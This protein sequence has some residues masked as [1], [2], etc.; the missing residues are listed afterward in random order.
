MRNV[1]IL[2]TFYLITTSGCGKSEDKSGAASPPDTKKAASVPAQTSRAVQTSGAKN[3]KKPPVAA[4]AAK[5]P[6]PGPSPIEKRLERLTAFMDRLGQQASV[7][8]KKLL[9]RVKLV[10]RGEK[11]SFQDLR[12]LRNIM[13]RNLFDL[14]RSNGDLSDPYRDY[15]KNMGSLMDEYSRCLILYSLPSD[16]PGRP[17]DNRWIRRLIMA[18]NDAARSN[19]ALKGLPAFKK[20]LDVPT[21]PMD[22]GTYA[23]KLRRAWEDMYKKALTWADTHPLAAP[24][25]TTPPKWMKHPRREKVMLLFMNLDTTRT[26]KWLHMLKCRPHKGKAP[27]GSASCSAIYDIMK[28]AQ[29][30]MERFDSSWLDAVQELIDIE[31]Q[32]PSAMNEKLSPLVDE[33]REMNGR[34]QKLR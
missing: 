34:I 9:D 12:E 6:T 16:A 13:E 31:P 22:S 29:R 30:V 2:L 26:F 10:E 7:S 5:Q 23:L 15:L 28:D 11:V 20:K 33:L 32:I 18:Y 3:P 19:N 8:V 4:P 17:T 14:I 25:S 21:E 1:L 24:S 27:K